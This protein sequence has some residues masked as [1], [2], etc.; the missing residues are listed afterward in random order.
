M[1]A[2]FLFAGLWVLTN[3]QAQHTKPTGKW[4]ASTKTETFW[5]IFKNDTTATLVRGK[6]STTGRFTLDTT[7][8][9]MHVDIQTKAEDG[10][11]G[12]R[13]RGI[14][15]HVGP[16]KIRVR[17]NLADPELRPKNF[18]PKGNAETLVFVK[19]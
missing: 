8:S 6:D 3:L 10:S 7:Q 9:P 17:F 4:K 16:S 18:M 1:K 13:L 14:M 12:L 15:E 5:L 11:M 19:Q 2:V